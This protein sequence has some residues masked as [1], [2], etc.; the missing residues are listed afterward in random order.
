VRES[1]LVLDGATGTELGRRGVD[2][3]PPFWSARALLDAPDV[4]AAVH[5]EYLEAGADAVITATFRTHA[6]SLAPAGRGDDARALTHQAVAIARDAR[7]RVR[8]GGQVLGGVA[9]LEDC[10]RPELAPDPDACRREHEAMITDLLDAGVDA[11][12][13]ETMGVA[14]E[15]IA[16]AEVARAL[17]PGRWMISFCARSDGPPGVLIDGH[18]VTALLEHLDG[19]AAVGFNC[20]AAPAMAAQIPVVRAALPATTD[21]IVYANTSRQTDDGAW[22][23]SDAT[24]P[25]RYANYAEQWRDAGATIIGGCCGTN[26]ETIRAVARRL[27]RGEPS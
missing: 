6:R 12:L 27:R 16:A 13:L 19:A 21:V 15:A 26:P 10:Y 14:H 3:A 7:D 11:I 1:I 4:L 23:D 22:R 2:L 9:P 5:A 20:V 18:P 17:A 8:P 25:D 24:D